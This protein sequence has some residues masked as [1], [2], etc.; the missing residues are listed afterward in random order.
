[1]DLLPLLKKIKPHLYELPQGSVPGMRV[2]A[3]VYA[4]PDLLEAVRNDR[5]LQQLA[6]VAMLPGVVDP[7]I[8]MPDMHEGY[9]FPIGGVAATAWPHGVISPGGV[10]YDINC[11]VRLLASDLTH[12][13][14]SSRLPEF[15]DAAMRSVPAGVGRG[16][17]L[18]VGPQALEAVLRHGAGWC[19]AQ[20]YGEDGDLE[21]TEEG[22]CLSGADPATVSD[23]ARARGRD[24]LGT[25]GSGN[26]FLEV[27]RVEKVFDEDTAKA[28]GLFPDQAVIMVHCGSRGLGHQVCTDHVRT[29]L[30]DLPHYGFTLPDPELACAPADSPAGS[31]YLA[32]M[33]A[34]ANFAWANR[35]IITH[36]LREQWEAVFGAGR[37]LRLVYDVCHNVA[38]RERHEWHGGEM[39]LLVHRKGATRAFGPGRPEVPTE[40]RAVGQPVFIPGTMGTASYVLCGTAMAMR[41]TYGTVCHGAGRQ[42]SRHAAQRAESGPAVRRRLESQGIVVRCH[43]DLGLAE[44]A[45]A[46]YKSIEAVVEV[47]ADAGLATRVARLKPTAVI[48]G[49]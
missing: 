14:I 27:Q 40:Y 18:T 35:Q 3:R 20:G 25:L 34:A 42:L 43:S 5:S 6:N 11:G 33:A 9:G 36:R 41:Q 28:F 7:V 13:E 4:S 19:L 10:G 16:G 2:S 49:E 24:Q 1:M 8:A 29:M 12:E 32:A 48:K 30:R 23:R 44:E 15:A 46:A 38:K 39:E 21:R 37:K 17:S 47:V 31:R 26:H 22:G 45:P